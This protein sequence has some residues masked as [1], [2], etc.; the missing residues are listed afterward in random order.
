MAGKITLLNLEVTYKCPN[1]CWFCYNSIAPSKSN[2]AIMTEDIIS[3]LP[4]ADTISFT[5]GEPM[6]LRSVQLNRLLS[7]A[8][9]LSNN[10]VV[11]TSGQYPERIKKLDNNLKVQFQLAVHGVKEL[12][13]SQVGRPGAFQRLAKTAKNLRVLG[14]RFST[15]TVVSHKNLDRLHEIIE[16][17]VAAGS[18]HIL[19]IRFNPRGPMDAKHMLT[20][21]EYQKMLAAAEDGFLDYGIPISLGIPHPSFLDMKNYP[22]VITAGCAAGR[23]AF[24]VSP[25]GEIRICGHSRRIIGH[26]TDGID[27]WR[28]MADPF[29]RA[30][31]KEQSLCTQPDN[32]RCHAAAETWGDSCDPYICLWSHGTL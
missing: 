13:D 22:H 32:S 4:P 16:W 26:Y 29:V 14:R 17:S 24:T 2:S 3:A 8:S 30:S 9:R 27:K 11:L 25:V 5:G 15:S 20:L 10:L 18:E 28:K 21:E 23:S 19:L 31:E 7:T 12:H 6:S 1:R